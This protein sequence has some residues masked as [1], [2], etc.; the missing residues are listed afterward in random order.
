MKSFF[1]ILRCLCCL[2]FFIQG[3]V[4]AVTANTPL[5]QYALSG[6]WIYV[7]TNDP[8]NGVCVFKA[9]GVTMNIYTIDYI[10][11][12]MLS[13]Y[14]TINIPNA[15][16][17]TFSPSGALAYIA[18][19]DTI[20]TVNTPSL[21][22]YGNSFTISSPSI[23]GAQNPKLTSMVYV[24]SNKVVISYIYALD[25]MN[26]IIYQIDPAQI[27]S[28]NSYAPSYISLPSDVIPQEMIYLNTLGGVLILSTNTGLA[29]VKL[30]TLRP[31]NNGGD[32]ENNSVVSSSLSSSDTAGNPLF[33]NPKGLVAQISSSFVGSSYI[34]LSG[35]DFYFQSGIVNLYVANS[36]SY[37]LAA[38]NLTNILTTLFPSKGGT[39]SS[40]TIQLTGELIPLSTQTTNFIPL[41]VTNVNGFLYV[42]TQN[43]GANNIGGNVCVIYPNYPYP[44]TLSFPS[45]VNPWC[46]VTSRSSSVNQNIYVGNVYVANSSRLS[47]QYYYRNAT[48]ESIYVGKNNVNNGFTGTTANAIKICN[49]PT[50]SQMFS[51]V[52]AANSTVAI[53]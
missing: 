9:D 47:F 44:Q 42:L 15:T 13:P 41:D 4:F 23:I 29:F 17:L 32:I 45:L 18:S 39:Y 3:S 34:T 33:V 36:G 31:S 12:Y 38:L 7:L 27:T 19:S 43:G 5:S 20:Y 16:G 25:S 14:Y 53:Q 8:N 49:V 37:T 48:T 21:T 46:F 11:P 35:N 22:Q 50:V 10:S 30:S 26:N 28:G 40:S 1:S 52:T 2:V 24:P 51:G 6:P